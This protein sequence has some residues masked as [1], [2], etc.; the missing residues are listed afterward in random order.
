M[1]KEL[2]QYELSDLPEDMASQVLTFIRFL[3]YTYD[4]KKTVMD[5][6]NEKRAF[7]M[8]KD[9]FISISDDFDETPE[10]FREYM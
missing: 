7:G 4:E 3:K 6:A 1:L 8:L 2:L 9:D 10:C 5:N